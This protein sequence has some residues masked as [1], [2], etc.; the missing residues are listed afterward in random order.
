MELWQQLDAE[1]NIS[2]NILS[3][4]QHKKLPQLSP[5]AILLKIDAMKSDCVVSY[6]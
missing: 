3:Q 4:W 5:A 2:G 6:R 1:G